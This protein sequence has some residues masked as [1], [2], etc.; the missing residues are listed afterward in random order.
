MA[1]VWLDT[2]S[3]AI[4]DRAIWRPGDQAIADRPIANSV[5]DRRYRHSL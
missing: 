4:G 2:G 5:A 3:S 1:G